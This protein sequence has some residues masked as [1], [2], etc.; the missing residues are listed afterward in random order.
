MV[1]KDR[2][3]SNW[4]AGAEG[5]QAPDQPK[6]GVGGNTV[7]RLSQQK[8]VDV[9]TRSYASPCFSPIAMLCPETFAL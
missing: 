9:I 4:Q 1:A 7:E 6:G 2:N 8:L 5:A 3:S